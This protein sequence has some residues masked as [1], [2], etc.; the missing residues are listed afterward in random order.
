MQKVALGRTGLMVS[1]TAFGALPIQRLDFETAG[2]ILRAAYEA[3]INFFDTARGYSDSEEKMG[4]ALSDVRKD[5]YIATKVSG[6]KNRDEVMSK[7]ETSLKNLKTDYVDVLQLHNPAPA[8]DPDDPQS[9]YAGLVEAR[10]QGMAKFIG[11]TSHKREIALEVI[12]SGLYD[13][14]QYPLSAISSESDYEIIHACKEHNVGCIAMKAMCGGLL[15]NATLAFAGLRRFENVVPIWGIQ[16][17]EELEEFLELE[18]NPPEWMDAIEAAI[19][20]EKEALAGDF[21]R[22]CGYCLPCPQDIPIPMAARMH[23]LLKRAPAE[24]FVTEQWQ[25]KMQ[26]IHLCKQCGACIERCPYELNTPEIL[27]KAVEEYEAYLSQ[28]AV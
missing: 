17:M 19:E 23:L 22:G 27:A 28:Q 2:K 16:R 10:E 4:E 21:C 25:E 26:R 15:K 12:R 13:T 14:M 9:T 5:I 11:Y 20:Q 6:A 7:L 24:N 18:A 1:R 3:G 8:P